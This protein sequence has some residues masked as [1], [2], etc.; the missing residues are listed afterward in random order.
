MLCTCGD[1]LLGTGGNSETAFENARGVDEGSNATSSDTGRDVRTGVDCAD[2]EVSLLWAKREVGDVREPS[3]G[4]NEECRDA[5]GL[6]SDA[7]DPFLCFFPNV[8]IV[9]LEMKCEVGGL[10]QRF[11]SFEHVE[12][13]DMSCLVKLFAS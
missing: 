6:S 9:R 4:V 11:K 5:S 3:A 8:T 7:F 1:G 13:C 12:I 10:T 2:S